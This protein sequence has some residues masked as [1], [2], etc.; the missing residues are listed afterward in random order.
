MEEPGFMEAALRFKGLMHVLQ[1]KEEKSPV[2]IAVGVDLGCFDSLLNIG[3]VSS[4]SVRRENFSEFSSLQHWRSKF[5]SSQNLAVDAKNNRFGSFV[6]S[7]TIRFE[8]QFHNFDVHSVQFTPTLAF[9][10][11]VESELSCRCEKLS[12]RFTRRVPIQFVL[13]FTPAIQFNVLINKQ[14]YACV[15]LLNSSLVQ[16]CKRNSHS[17][18]SFPETQIIAG[19]F[20]SKQKELSS[21]E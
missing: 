13:G 20:E 1:K 19:H 21:S 14:L 5:L 18:N 9:K 7:D 4:E 10:I 2:H 15:E 12:V 8:V 6:E 17:L 16:K 3:K 11:F